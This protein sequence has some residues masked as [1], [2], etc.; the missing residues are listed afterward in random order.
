MTIGG[1]SNSGQNIAGG[2]FD[3]DQT[4]PFSYVIDLLGGDNPATGAKVWGPGTL[5][6]F[7]FDPFQ[8]NSSFGQSFEISAITFGSELTPIPEPSALVALVGMFGLGLLR[9]RPR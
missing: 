4:A 5:D 9:R 8:G 2:A 6:A 1:G 7:R 3:A